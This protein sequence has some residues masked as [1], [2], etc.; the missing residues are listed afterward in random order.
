MAVLLF[1]LFTAPVV[2]L[3]ALLAE[4]WVGRRMR[5]DARNCVNY[6]HVY[7]LLVGTAD[8]TQYNRTSLSAHNLSPG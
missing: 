5:E 3:A 2:L 6:G 8:I 4:P 1:I 7:T